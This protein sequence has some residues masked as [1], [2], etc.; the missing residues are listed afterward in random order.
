VQLRFVANYPTVSGLATILRLMATSA[1]R[2]I[3]LVLK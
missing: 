2:V 3:Y 1:F